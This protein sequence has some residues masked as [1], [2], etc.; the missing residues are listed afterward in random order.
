MIRHSPLRALGRLLAYVLYTLPLMPVQ[1]FAVLFK[2]PLAVTLPLAYHRRCAGLLGF[3]LRTHG[4]LSTTRPTLFVCNHVTYLDIVTL[5]ATLPASFVAKSEVAGWPFFGLLARLQRS[6]FVDRRPRSTAGQRDA[7]QIRLESGD[8]LI[9]FPE[10]TSSNGSWVLPFKS[11]LFSVAEREV[12]GRPLVVQPVSVA[13]SAID[14]LP[15]GRAHM[16][17]IAWYGEMGMAG[18]IW[19]VLGLG[20]IAVDI[21]LHEPTSH[22]EFA[23]RRDMARV[24]HEAVAGGVE[25]ALAGR[26]AGG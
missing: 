10:G 6:V 11:A 1:A 21:V 13:Y 24:C 26:L 3:E 5:G 25:R 9:L 20:R 8:N 17:R 2:R 18:H 7:M 19:N 14:G 4:T 16:P 23:N 15:T 12:G 22:A